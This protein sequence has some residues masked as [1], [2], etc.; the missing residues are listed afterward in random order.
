[1]AVALIWLCVAVAISLC[2]LTVGLLVYRRYDD[3]LTTYLLGRI[4]VQSVR[5]GLLLPMSRS[6]CESV[7]L[8]VT[9][10][11]CA[12][13]AERIEMPFEVWTRVGSKNHVAY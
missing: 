5:C 12:K 10:V 8:L 7:C 9:T 6:L 3:L 13:T 11:S 1:M 4:A 2:V